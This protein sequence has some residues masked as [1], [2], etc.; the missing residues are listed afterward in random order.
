[1]RT[2]TWAWLVAI[3]CSGQPADKGADTGADGDT[4]VDTDTD[5][6]ADADT[7]TPTACAST[8]SGSVQRSGGAVVDSEIR[9]CRGLLCRTD[10]TDAQGG[11]GFTNFATVLVPMLFDCSTTRDVPTELLPLDPESALG[12]TAAEHPVGAGLYVTVGVN[13][14]EPP[15]FGPPPDAVAGVRV[16]DFSG[17]PFDGIEGTVLAMW[18]VAP[19]NYL[20]VPSAGLP[21]RIDNEWALADD[22][23]LEVY[24][25]SYDDNQW[26]SGGTAT[27]QG[28]DLV[29]AAIPLVSTVILVQP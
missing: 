9:L 22:T 12:A 11:F 19:F 13:D 18:Y 16:V 29:G 28:P 5:T 6:D 4:D 3:A 25:G 7:D 23:A 21:I 26:L 8:L 20:A 2:Y 1:M 17:I 15:L 24:V 14:L 10:D 27:A